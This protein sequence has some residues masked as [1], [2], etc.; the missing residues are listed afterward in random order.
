M[1]GQALKNKRRVACSFLW[2]SC[3]FRKKEVK[4]SAKEFKK[5]QLALYLAEYTADIY[6][7]SLSRDC[8]C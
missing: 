1:E 3:F 2:H 5:T 8:P 4:R 7:S 6:V